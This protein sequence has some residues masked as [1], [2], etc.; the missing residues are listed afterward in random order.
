MPNEKTDSV[1][2]LINTHM[3]KVIFGKNRC[4]VEMKYDHLVVEKFSFV[5]MV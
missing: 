1:F 3:N 5:N 4:G 2:A